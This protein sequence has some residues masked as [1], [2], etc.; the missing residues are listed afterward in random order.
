MEVGELSAATTHICVI[1][2]F[3]GYAVFLLFLSGN[4]LIV[5]N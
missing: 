4:L 3:T 5:N 1:F 2:Y